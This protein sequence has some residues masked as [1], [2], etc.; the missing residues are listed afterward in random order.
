MRAAVEVDKAL[1]KLGKDKTHMNFANNLERDIALS[2][3]KN[4]DRSNPSNE[5]VDNNGFP[6]T[7]E[8][9]LTKVLES[10]KSRKPKPTIPKVEEKIKSEINLT[11]KGEN[12]INLATT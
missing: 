1:K 6:N 4:F 7:F 2:V 3:L 5:S 10:V 11:I 8:K 9:V 12:L